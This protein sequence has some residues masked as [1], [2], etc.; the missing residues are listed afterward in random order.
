MNP[1]LCI[2]AFK[3]LLNSVNSL[4]ELV[5]AEKLDCLID[6]PNIS[7]GSQDSYLR[8]LFIHFSSLMTQLN[9]LNIKIPPDRSWFCSIATT[10]LSVATGCSTW[11]IL[12]MTF[13]RFYS[14]IRPHKAASFNTVKKAKVV[15][16]SIFIIFILYSLPHFF[17]TIPNGNICVPYAKGMGHL[18]GK[19]YYWL[20]IFIGFGF[21]FVA[22]LLMNSVIIHTLCK[23]SSLLLAKAE[24]QG[25]NST[26]L[27]SSE[28]QIIIMLLLVTF[29]FLILM[30]PSYGM[31]F[32]TIFVDFSRS[33][34]LYAGFFLFASI[35]QK[36]FYTNFGINFYLYVISG[37]KFRSDLLKLFKTLFPFCHKKRKGPVE[38]SI[39]K[40]SSFNTIETF[41]EM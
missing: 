5:K 13:E 22:L 41:T 29:G 24:P 20:D 31:T 6:L 39:S 40:S 3:T 37:T 18:A 25:Q 7:I 11:F 16:L 21:P 14:I 9:Y 1:S 12:S 28:K 10:I 4:T 32:Y 26:K 8:I 33:R 34:K 17:M 23:R 15:I 35:G 36:T 30:S 2:I 27:R 38:T 19:V